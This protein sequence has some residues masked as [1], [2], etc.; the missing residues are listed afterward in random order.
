MGI[1]LGLLGFGMFSTIAVVLINA[2]MGWLT[3]IIPQR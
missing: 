2:I 1:F 3:G